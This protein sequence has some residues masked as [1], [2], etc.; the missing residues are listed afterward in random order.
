M[1]KHI[2]VLTGSP[3]AGGNSDQMA[4][5]FIRGAQQ[6]GHEVTKIHTASLN[7]KGCMA[8]DACYSTGLACVQNDDFDQ[9]ALQFEKSDAVVFATPIYW[10]AFPAQLKAVID[11]FYSF[12]VGKKEIPVK[13]SLLLVCGEMKDPAIFDG[14]INSYSQSAV[15][16]NWKDRGCFYVTGVSKKGD[17]LSTDSLP[18]IE[19]IGRTF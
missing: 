6:A 15:Y 12:L 10:F 5:A 19:E 18:K 11:K 16:M 7:I 2:L 3:R 13:E 14:I 4:D 9:I 17:I 1:K 8:C